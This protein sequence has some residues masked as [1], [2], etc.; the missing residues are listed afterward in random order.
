[1]AFQQ[2]FLMRR[3]SLDFVDSHEVVSMLKAICLLDCK[4]LEYD[5]ALI[6]FAG[7]G[8]VI[9]ELLL[10]QT[11]C[12]SIYYRMHEGKAL[13]YKLLVVYISKSAINHYCFNLP[14]IA[15]IFYGIRR[16]N[17]HISLLSRLYCTC[18]VINT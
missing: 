12:T 5:E 18:D 7:S 17:N 16:K 11:L 8:R 1:L 2:I 3:Y 4:I 14:G 6:T 13:V 9:C 15:Y 10:I